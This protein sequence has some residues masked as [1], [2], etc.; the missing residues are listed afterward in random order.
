MRMRLA[1]AIVVTT[2]AR[3]RRQIRAPLATARGEY[4]PGESAYSSLARR[5]PQ[6]CARRRAPRAAILVLFG[7]DERKL[8][9]SVRRTAGVAN[10]LHASGECAY[11]RPPA[12]WR[13]ACAGGECA[14]LRCCRGLS[15]A[16]NSLVR[17]EMVDRLY[18]GFRAVLARYPRADVVLKVED[19]TRVDGAA[20]A[21][22]LARPICDGSS[23]SAW[24]SP[25][26]PPPTATPR[27]SAQPL[28]K[29]PPGRA[30]AA[31]LLRRR[32]RLPLG[33][34]D[35]AAPAARDAAAAGPGGRLL[36]GARPRR[37]RPPG[38]RV[39]PQ[40]RV[41]PRRRRVGSARA[42]ARVRPLRRGHAASVLVRVGLWTRGS[43]VKSVEVP[44]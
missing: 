27:S 26:G 8:R 19:D 28:R 37:R 9:E 1:L 23:Y 41:P 16:N 39:W 11:P 20:L 33:R 31:A 44:E 12:W 32:Q 43:L 40:P 25:G 34:A 35:P 24:K 6:R 4:L 10:V 7:R 29:L 22:L 13:A 14:C 42:A 15:G 3:P 21:A 18:E 36:L 5:R 17:Y 38:A 30:R 2:E